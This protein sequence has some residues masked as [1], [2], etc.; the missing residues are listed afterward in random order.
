MDSDSDG[1]GKRFARPGKQGQQRVPCRRAARKDLLFVA[2]ENKRAAT[3]GRS[4]LRNFVES[5]VSRDYC[6]GLD[7]CC[8]RNEE[9]AASGGINFLRSEI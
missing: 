7:R 8:S 2:R 5:L 4:S 9:P 6:F 3:L 1:K